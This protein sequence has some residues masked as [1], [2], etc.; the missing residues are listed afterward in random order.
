MHSVSFLLFGCLMVVIIF[1]SPLIGGVNLPSGV[2]R[3]LDS[4]FA[5]KTDQNIGCIR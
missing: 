5:Y 2:W 4:K 1:P 3:K